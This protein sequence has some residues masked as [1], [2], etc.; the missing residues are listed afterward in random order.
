MSALA[1]VFSGYFNLSSLTSL[2]VAALVSVLLALLAVPLQAA[3]TSAVRF[4][5][6]QASRLQPVLLLRVSF[7]DQAFT[8]SREDFQKLMFSADSALSSVTNYYLENSYGDFLLQPVAESQDVANDGIVDIV[9]PGNHPNI[10]N[11]YGSASAKLVSDA[12]LAAS[13]YVDFAQFDSNRNDAIDASELAIVFM[14]AGYENAFGGANAPKPNVWSHQK[15]ISLNVGG[16]ELTRCAMFGEKHQNH[17]ATIGIISHEM[18]HLLFDLPDLYDRDW[19]SNGIGRWGLMGLGSWNNAGGLSGSSPAHM[20]AWSK[21]KAGFLKPTDITADQ[22]QFILASSSEGPHALRI[23]IDPFRHG[24]HFLLEYRS[25]ANFDRGLPGYGLLISHID[26][27]VG[28]GKAGSQNDVAERKLVDIEEADGRKDLDNLNNRGDE[29]DVFN[30]ASGQNYFGDKSLPATVDYAGDDSGVEIFDIKVGDVV[31]GLVSL[32]HKNMQGRLGDNIGYADGDDYSIYKGFGKPEVF[33]KQEDAFS[34][35]AANTPLVSVVAFT[36]NDRDSSANKMQWL[37]GVDVFS[38]AVGNVSMSV[39]AAFDD[40]VL[41]QPMAEEVA[42]SVKAG[43][44]RIVF[45]A[46]VL[47]GNVEEVFVQLVSDGALSVD[48]K[49]IVSGRSFI[50]FETADFEAADFDFNQRLLV[51][52]H[53]QDFATAARSDSNSSNLNSSN[54]N[55]SNLNIGS[56]VS[57]N[58]DASSSSAGALGFFFIFLIAVARFF[59]S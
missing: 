42:Y 17:L 58:V 5:G 24:E 14:V 53:G 22:T 39:F 30:D 8:F 32:P 34:N 46:P 47:A 50:R 25:D 2:A 59:R 15:E 26:D 11:N 54:A 29:L 20:M 19:Q 6:K 27:R 52:S 38:P 18:G 51:S 37:H 4:D 41:T 3:E 28:Y 43:W 48:K 49:G 10:G 35:D 7:S 12:L 23:W 31:T 55:N 36:L 44:N 21:Q 33:G 1:S 9:L 56:S 13:D 57:V 40:Q 45:A 16:V